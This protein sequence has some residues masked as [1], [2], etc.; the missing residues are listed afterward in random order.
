M[1]EGTGSGG[2]GA[3]A[4]A[5]VVLG[6]APDGRP[7]IPVP[8]RLA[9]PTRPVTPVTPIASTVRRLVPVAV[10]GLRWVIYRPLTVNAGLALLASEYSRSGSAEFAGPGQLPAALRPVAM[11]TGSAGR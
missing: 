3:D 9:A 4:L 6:V 1:V 8:S 11:A 7:R 5:G 2:V 10:A